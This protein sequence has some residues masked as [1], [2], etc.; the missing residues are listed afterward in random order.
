L[1][2]VNSE[3]QQSILHYPFTTNSW[4]VW[5]S[6]ATFGEDKSL[7]LLIGAGVKLEDNLDFNIEGRLIGET[8]LSLSFGYRF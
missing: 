7:G 6:N 3:S 2:R 5:T 4:R 1:S 8:A